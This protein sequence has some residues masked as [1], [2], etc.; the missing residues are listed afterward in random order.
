[1]DPV[2]VIALLLVGLQCPVDG[3]LRVDGLLDTLT[4][5]LCQPTLERF[6]LGRGDGLDDTQD[7][8][9]IGNVR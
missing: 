8:F 3:L 1:M 6:C 2:G 4:T 5:N 7:L 9:R